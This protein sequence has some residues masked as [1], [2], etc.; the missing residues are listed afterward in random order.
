[1]DLSVG[2]V[3]R[4]SW[5]EYFLGLAEHAATRATCPRLSVG[6]VAV[7]NKRV[8]ST[9]YNGTGPG[10]PH[11][12]HPIDEPCR[13]ARHAEW[14]ALDPRF[15][16]FTLATLYLTHSPCVKCQDVIITEGVIRVVYRVPYRCPDLSKL[17]AARVEVVHLP[18]EKQ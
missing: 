18:K 1:M 8:L 10:E 6:A 9:G 11:C 15:G 5:D 4:P 16:P 17:A 7:R 2:A 12:R 13:E 14:N 3:T